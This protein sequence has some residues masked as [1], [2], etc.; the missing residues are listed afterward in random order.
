MKPWQEK[1]RAR[2]RRISRRRLVKSPLLAVDIA[3]LFA[4]SLIAYAMAKCGSLAVSAWCFER[5]AVWSRK[6]THLLDEY[7]DIPLERRPF[8]YRRKAIIEMQSLWFAA[9]K[10]LDAN[11]EEIRS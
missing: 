4:C 3:Y 2:R 5:A 9:A 10:Q 7:L 11:A 1:Q 6:V 8:A